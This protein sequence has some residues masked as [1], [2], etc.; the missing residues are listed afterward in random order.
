MERCGKYWLVVAKPVKPKLSPFSDHLFWPLIELHQNV[1]S[2]IYMFKYLGL[3]Y[4][5]WFWVPARRWGLW[6]RHGL[7][8]QPGMSLLLQK[9]I[10]HGIGRVNITDIVKVV[11][12][13]PGLWHRQLHDRIWPV[14]WGTLEPRWWLLHKKVQTKIYWNQGALCNFFF[15]FRCRPDNLCYHGEVKAIF[16][17][18]QQNNK[19]LNKTKLD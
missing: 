2:Y 1:S 11:I 18:N 12:F 14:F 4:Q 5:R 19:I 6:P 16:D 9:I 10:S 8:W 13:S 7:F 15:L 3:M 17:P